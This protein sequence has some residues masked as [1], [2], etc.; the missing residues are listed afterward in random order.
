MTA[1]STDKEQSM[2]KLRHIAMQVPDLEKAA[3]FYETV[4]GMERVAHG[5]TPFGNAIMLSDGVMNMALLNFPEGTI[6]RVNGPDWA[7]LH[8]FGFVVDDED[9]A[10]KAITDAGGEPYRTD[11]PE[12]IPALQAEAK[13][14]DLNGVVFDI[15][16]HGWST[17]PR[18]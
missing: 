3:Q 14:K 18:K 10:G 7:G 6:G 1:A 11:L 5:D 9:E 4:F 2:A 17:S 15:T 13:Y 12:G 16:T 8:H